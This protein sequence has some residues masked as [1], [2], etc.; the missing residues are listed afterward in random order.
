[1]QKQHVVVNLWCQKIQDP[2]IRLSCVVGEQILA[3]LS[4]FE[5]NKHFYEGC[6]F[7]EDDPH[8]GRPKSVIMSEVIHSFKQVILNSEPD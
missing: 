6:E 2:S 5:W 7:T 1:M 4:V 3:H 8:V